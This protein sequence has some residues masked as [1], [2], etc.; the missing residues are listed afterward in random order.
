MKK[1]VS[2]KYYYG[3]M[4]KDS[5]PAV[6]AAQLLEEYRTT[7]PNGACVFVGNAGGI[8]MER[9]GCECDA[10]VRFAFLERA[11]SPSGRNKQGPVCRFG[12]SFESMSPGYQ[13]TLVFFL[14]TT[15]KP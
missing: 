4:V 11:L 5:D 7:L 8:R 15:L 10:G 13:Q 6:Q 12:A 1:Y 14:R 2:V 3:R 9:D